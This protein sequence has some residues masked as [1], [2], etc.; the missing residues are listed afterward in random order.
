[1]SGKLQR[2]AKKSAAKT[3]KHP[4]LSV[5]SVCS[6]T[7]NCT[8]TIDNFILKLNVCDYIGEFE[9]R[10]LVHCSVHSNEIS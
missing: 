8:C 3:G 4:C 1:M 10:M 6:V 7:P 5:M 2:E 9:V